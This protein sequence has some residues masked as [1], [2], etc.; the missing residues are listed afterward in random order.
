M[1]S[2]NCTWWLHK[3]QMFS[4]VRGVSIGHR[5]SK[6]LRTHVQVRSNC[7]ITAQRLSSLEQMLLKPSYIAGAIQ[8]FI[9][10]YKMILTFL[11]NFSWSFNYLSL[12]W[13]VNFPRYPSAKLFAINAFY[14]WRLDWMTWLQ[15][16]NPKLISKANIQISNHEKI[17]LWKS[18]IM[19]AMQLNSSCL[20]SMKL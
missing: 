8:K 11:K 7:R 3:N 2:L 14:V 12:F 10:I 19:I 18:S 9:I 17:K 20:L 4:A 15:D 13:L 16:R 6:S 5:N 1:K